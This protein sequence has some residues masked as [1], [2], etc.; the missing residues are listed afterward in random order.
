MTYLDRVYHRCAYVKVCT[1]THERAC[2]TVCTCMRRLTSTNIFFKMHL[3]VFTKC[4]LRRYPSNL[5][6][7][8]LWQ[9]QFK[10]HLSLIRMHPIAAIVFF[11]KTIKS[12]DADKQHHITFQ[13]LSDKL[14]KFCLANLQLGLCKMYFLNACN[15]KSSE[16]KVIMK[17]QANSITCFVYCTVYGESYQKKQLN[18]NLVTQFSS[19]IQKNYV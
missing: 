8:Q 16:K 14:V 15:H 17:F 7:E 13:N 3:Y 18:Q 2:S 1:Y 12:Y 11:M 10:S 19:Q 4:F 6:P 9:S 5:L